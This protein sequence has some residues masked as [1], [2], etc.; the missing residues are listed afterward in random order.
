MQTE[1]EGEKDK[2]RGRDFLLTH[3]F[4]EPGLVSAPKLKHVYRKTNMSS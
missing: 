4:G 2:G 1:I 3:K